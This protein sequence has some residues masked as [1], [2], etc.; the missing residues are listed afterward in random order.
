ML[1]SNK[2]LFFI[3]LIIVGALGPLFQGGGKAPFK[4][5][6]LSVLII[7][8]T[9]LRDKLTPD[10]RAAILAVGEG[11][12]DAK[13]KQRGGR[14]YILDVENTDLSQMPKWAQDA[15]AVPHPTVPWIIAAGPKRGSSEPLPETMPK[16][17]EVAEAAK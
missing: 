10:Q 6:Q 7:E 3:L 9:R 2:N 12:L 11:S 17:L 5:D 16:I 8:E 15:A 4:T 14:F 13:I 1:S